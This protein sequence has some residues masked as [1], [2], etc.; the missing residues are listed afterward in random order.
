MDNSSHNDIFLQ[1]TEHL[2]G[3][4]IKCALFFVI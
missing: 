2:V 3:V 4:N 1:I